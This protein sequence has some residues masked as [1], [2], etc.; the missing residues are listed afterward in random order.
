MTE[1]SH[2]QMLEGRR[3]VLR[4]IGPEDYA[5]VY[6]LETSP[7]LLVR[8]RFHG[9]T[10]SPEESTRSLFDGVLAQFLAVEKTSGKPIGFVN[11]HDP[12]LFNATAHLAAIAMPDS[13]N[14]ALMIDACMPLVEYAFALFPMRKLY[15]EV[16]DFNLVQFESIVGKFFETEGCLVGDH[17]F[18]GQYWNKHIL[19]ITRE[20]WTIAREKYMGFVGLK[21]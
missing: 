17:Y 1:G 10:P 13:R 20:K 18:N 11:V 21:S 6:R 4:A 2:G 12:N 9:R 15:A 16:L 8:W 7:E 3:V 19:A 14:A 5:F